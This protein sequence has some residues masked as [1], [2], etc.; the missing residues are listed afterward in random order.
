MIYCPIK[1]VSHCSNFLFAGGQILP[2]LLSVEE[3][4]RCLIPEG[5]FKN[6]CNIYF[7]ICKYPEGY[8]QDNTGVHGSEGLD[9]GLSWTHAS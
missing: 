8:L 2:P 6:L 3:L 5:F 7:I 9:P 4:L 1:A